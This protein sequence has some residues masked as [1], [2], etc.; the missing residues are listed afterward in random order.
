MVSSKIANELLKMAKELLSDY[1]IATKELGKLI[2]QKLSGDWKYNKKSKS[3]ELRGNA[4]VDKF[5]LTFK[6]EDIYDLKQQM[7]R[8]LKKKFKGYE[9]VADM[10][11]SYVWISLD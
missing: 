3:W 4:D 1:D 10:E 6:S 2:K 5:Y 7:L 9:I 11:D 8:K